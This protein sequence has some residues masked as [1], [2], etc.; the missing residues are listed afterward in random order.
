MPFSKQRKYGVIYADP[1]WFRNWI[2]QEVGHNEVSHY[3]CLNFGDLARLPVTDLAA[4]HCVLFLWTTDSYLPRAL[5]LVQAWGFQYWTVA[6]YWV[7]LNPAAKHVGFTGFGYW[8]RADTEQC[9]LATRGNPTRRAKDVRRLI[10]EPRLEHDRKPDCAR[11]RIER[12]VAGPYL[13]LFARETKK[14]WDCWGNQVG[15]FDEGHAATRQP[16]H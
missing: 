14:G 15:L 6:F 4:N 5:E 8:T 10:V 12:L 3:D 1:P 9:L 16:L 13:D 11:D 7:K 2:P